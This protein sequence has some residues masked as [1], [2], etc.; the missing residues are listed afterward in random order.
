MES[1]RIKG[2]FLSIIFLAVLEEAAGRQTALG[3]AGFPK[4]W[5]PAVRMWHPPAGEPDA[6]HQN[7][8]SRQEGVCKQRHSGKK[9]LRLMSPFV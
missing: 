5:P 1:V 9:L 6:P 8:M 4:Q 2:C 3:L 7:V